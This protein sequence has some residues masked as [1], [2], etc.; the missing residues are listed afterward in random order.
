MEMERCQQET[1]S[2]S[3]T[4]TP[5]G[6]KV[7]QKCGVERPMLSLHIIPRD[8]PTEPLFNIYSRRK[9]FQNLAESVFYP[10]PQTKDNA[11]LE[12]L[13]VRAPFECKNHM[14]NIIKLCPLPDKRYSQ[15]HLM[16]KLFTKDYEA[17]RPIKNT[18]EFIKRLLMKFEDTETA[19]RHLFPSRQ[20]F[21]YCWLLSKNLDEYRLHDYKPFVKLL[22]C[23]KRNK[24]Y[25]EMYTEIVAYMKPL[26][27]FNRGPCEIRMG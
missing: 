3:I 24:Y 15:I 17:P 7:C 5:Y 10:T 13:D 14:L 23:K 22:K 26:D 19:F 25:D 21:N 8:W 4:V 1:C 12:Y 27:C 6:S 16:C 9:R 11:I 20:F 18:Q 2:G